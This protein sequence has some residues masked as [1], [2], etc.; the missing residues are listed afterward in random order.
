M[1]VSEEQ[2]HSFVIKFRLEES[3]K[4]SRQF[5]WRGH[6]T[7]VASGEFRYLQGLSSIAKFIELYL[8]NWKIGSGEYWRI[9]KWLL[10]RLLGSRNLK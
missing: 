3:V 6:I 2:T 5:I 7:H 1:E 8:G 10:K 4:Q 9:K